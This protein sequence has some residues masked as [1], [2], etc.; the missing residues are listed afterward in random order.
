MEILSNPKLRWLYLTVTFCTV[1]AAYPASID[2]IHSEEAKSVIKGI[3]GLITL[4]C[5]KIGFTTVPSTK[6][7]EEKE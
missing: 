1:V 7:G 3:A 5:S 4:V 6:E 2:F